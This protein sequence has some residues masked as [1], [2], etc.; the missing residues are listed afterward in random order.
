MSR[1]DDFLAAVLQSPEDDGHRLIYADWLD[2][3]DDPRGEFIRVQIE[4]AATRTLPD[5]GNCC[6][7][8]TTCLPNGARDGPD[9]L[10]GRVLRW[11]FHRGSR[12]R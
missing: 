12:R 9:L 2:E 10:I 1:H 3:Q 4:L 11:V 5:A 8:S 7:A 6:D